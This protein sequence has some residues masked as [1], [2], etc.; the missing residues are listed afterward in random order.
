MNILERFKIDIIIAS[1]LSVLNILFLD[2]ISFADG[3]LLVII[4]IGLI[5]G[6]VMLVVYKIVKKLRKLRKNKKK[7][8]NKEDKLVREEYV[9]ECIVRIVEIVETPVILVDEE[10]KTLEANDSAREHFKSIDVGVDILEVIKDEA[11]I[12]A[13]QKVKFEPHEMFVEFTENKMEYNASIS[14]IPY[15]ENIYHYLIKCKS[16]VQKRVKSDID[17][18]QLIHHQMKVAK[19]VRDATTKINELADDIFDISRSSS[20]HNNV[21]GIKKNVVVIDKAVHESMKFN[22]AKYSIPNDIDSSKGNINKILNG[23]HS[24]GY[25]KKISK[26]RD[27]Q[28]NYREL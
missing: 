3:D 21:V 24:K 15:D 26:E 20:I 17:K 12:E 13:V 11:F 23:G 2:F 10:F 16:L 1:C 9:Q 28:E 8:K 18:D 4:P 6:S 19:A 5:I 25:K 14:P 22:D 27:E 7:R